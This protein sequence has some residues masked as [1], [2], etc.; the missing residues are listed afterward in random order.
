[1]IENVVPRKATIKL[2]EA[3]RIGSDQRETDIVQHFFAAMRVKQNDENPN[4][5]DAWAE[6][7]SCS[8]I[9]AALLAVY[10]KPIDYV[11]EDQDELDFYA[12]Q[13]FPVLTTMVDDPTE[14]G[15]QD[16]LINVINDLT[17]EAFWDNDRMIEWLESKGL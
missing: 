12:V 10:P 6:V 14:E 1:M 9:G 15:F 8:A 3:V 16:Q 7:S 5:Y 13:T 2:S 17:F 11:W 4:C